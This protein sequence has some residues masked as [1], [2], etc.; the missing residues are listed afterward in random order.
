[1]P[2]FVRARGYPVLPLEKLVNHPVN[3]VGIGGWHMCPFGFVIA[4]LQVKEVAEYDEYVVFLV[5]P[6]Q[7]TFSRWVPIMLGT[8]TL[9][10]II[11]S[12]KEIELDQL[13]MP[14]ATIRLAQLLSQRG[15]VEDTSQEGTVGGQEDDN[16]EEINVVV[17]LKD[18]VYVGPFQMEI[19]KG[20]VKEPP[21][22]DAHVII[23]PVRY[24]EVKKGQAHLL[25]LG[26]QVLHAYFTLTVGNH[27]ISIVVQNMSDGA[28]LLKKDMPVA[29]MVSAMLV[30]LANLTSEEEIVAGMEV[31]QEQMSIEE[32]QHKL[33][34]KLNLDGLSQWS[35]RNVATVRELLLSYYDVFTLG[36]SELGC[37]S[38]I[39]HEIHITDDE[40]L[41]ECF[42]HIPL[43][44]LEEV[45]ALLRDML[46]VG[47]IWPSQS[48]W[49]N[50]VVLVWKKDGALHF[51][52]D[53]RKL[54]A[55]TKKD[56][57]PLPQIQEVLE[58][59]S[60][61]TH[62]S[63]MDFKSG[64]WQVKMAPKSQQYTTFT[65][66]N[67]GFYEF[68]RMSFGLCNAPA[69]FQHLMQNALGELNLTYCV[70]YLDNVIIFGYAEDKH[71][72]CLWVVLNHIRE[73]N[74][75]L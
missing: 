39:K 64:F 1:M 16:V 4:R 48:P 21:T 26:L 34:E 60:G 63:T 47:A 75:K 37:T 8:C 38:A 42:R 66:G 10:R 31:P 71:L 12:I 19:L 68:I 53:F 32:H 24:S 27:N 73:F 72:E 59:M 36:P 54:N 25:P 62:F 45:H 46:E 67:L 57:Y 28:I 22:C 13:V 70:I 5:I 35:P 6:D 56:S 74:L 41:K 29:Q 30:P 3:L 14:W 9:G 17:G 52:I 50:T 51:C 49:C 61:A 69:T 40:P 11:N 33:L 23:T 7:S 58:S 44:L 2:E 20:K 15:W 55:R 18:S 43:P 65:I